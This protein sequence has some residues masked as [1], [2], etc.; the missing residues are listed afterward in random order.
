M[1]DHVEAGGPLP[2]HL[3]VLS[4]RVERAEIALHN[5]PLGLMRV[6]VVAPFVQQLPQVAVERRKR[7]V[8]I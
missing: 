3:A 4:L 1:F 2:K 8:T 6:R 5:P 7:D